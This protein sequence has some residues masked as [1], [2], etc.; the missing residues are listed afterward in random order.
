MTKKITLANVYR[1]DHTND[2]SYHLVMTANIA[3][4]AEA[5]EIAKLV[6][7]HKVDDI[8]IAG[9][10]KS[11]DRLNANG[12]DSHFGQPH[13]DTEI[14]FVDGKDEKIMH[15]HVADDYNDII[16]KG[17]GTYRGHHIIRDKK[18]LN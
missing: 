17:H 4:Q 6:A 13:K 3:N 16:K 18:S 15:L 1:V 12:G 7:T 2:N 8:S 5:P 11:Y 14:Y 10:M 9:M